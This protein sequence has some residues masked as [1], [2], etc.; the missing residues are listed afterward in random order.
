VEFDAEYDDRG[1]RLRERFAEAEEVPRVIYHRG[2]FGIEPITYVLGET[3][4]EAA[5]LAIELIE[6]V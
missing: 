3:G 6:S 4:V 2:A 5:E 1:E